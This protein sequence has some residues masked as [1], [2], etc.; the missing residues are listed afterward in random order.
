MRCRFY[1]DP[2][3]GEPHIFRHGVTESE[4]EEVLEAPGEVRRDR[5]GA[6]KANGQTRSG[7]HLTVI[8][9]L[10]EDEEEA[11]V[12]TAYDLSGK[13]LAAFRRRKK[14]TNK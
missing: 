4:V 11:F 7:R 10:P 13:P 6:M 14:R 12:L 9:V 3:S 8:Y 5:D 2:E 1:R